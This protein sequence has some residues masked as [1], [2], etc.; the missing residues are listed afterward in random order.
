MVIRRCWLER[1]WLKCWRANAGKVAIADTKGKKHY[2]QGNTPG[3]P[4]V[5][6]YA[7]PLG[8]FIGFECKVGKNKQT[9]YQKE[10]ESD[11]YLK[12]AAYFLIRSLEDLEAALIKIRPAGALQ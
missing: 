5:I 11:S 1:Q 6:G 9:D 3:T 7:A 10:F 12:G 8:R 2:Y 4:D